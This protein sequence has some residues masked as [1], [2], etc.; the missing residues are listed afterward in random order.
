VIEKA[1][2]TRCTGHG[3]PDGTSALNTLSRERYFVCR[4]A[5]GTGLA[6]LR[7]KIPS[8]RLSANL[9]FASRQG[10]GKWLSDGVLRGIWRTA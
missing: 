9:K 5:E 3:R 7:C 8:V 1:H 6:Y 2:G 10:R 4:P